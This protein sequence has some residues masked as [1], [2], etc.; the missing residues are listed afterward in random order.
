MDPLTHGV[1][2][3]MAAYSVS[4]EKNRKPAVVAGAG[5]A[6]IADV[7]TFIHL[8]S[9]PLFN[10]EVHRQFTHALVFIPVG[11]LIAA[12]LF[13]WVLRR[14]LTFRDLYLYSLAGYATHW[15]MDV[16]T[17]YGTEL[18]WPFVDTR[19]AWN[20]V[21]VVDPVFSAGLIL[22][23][24]LAIGLNKKW[25]IYVAW[26]WMA[27]ILAV[28]WMQNNRAEGAM[29]QTA[30]ERGH[31]IERSVVK[32]TIGNQV[33]WRT[34]YISGDSVFTD[35]VRTGY[36]SGITVFPGEGEPLVFIEDE[37]S[38]FQGRTL[39]SDLQRFE[40]LSEAYLI[41]H[42]DKPDVI[43]DARY[44]MLPTSLIPL[45]GVETDTTNTDTH[46]PFLYFRD[47]G[48]EIRTR[49]S[50]MLFGRDLPE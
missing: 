47:S 39:Y 19:F 21:S 24:A 38:E 37:F 1:V 10:L 3:A 33:L 18:F 7:E 44:S 42:P 28:G 48:E 4:S 26:A 22:F 8:P 35:G 9:D 14:H 12:A 2:G 6:L 16:I 30:A 34:T 15:F 43:G 27:I 41:R 36:F 40:R 13:W 11:A 31:F 50:G 5:A 17:S 20:L 45:W 32:P 49:F 23:T 25:L 29:T 46:L